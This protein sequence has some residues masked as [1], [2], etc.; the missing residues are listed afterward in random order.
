LDSKIRVEKQV[1]LKLALEN[2]DATLAP[3]PISTDVGG[4][5]GEPDIDTLSNILK[6]FN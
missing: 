5:K 3:V 2:T 4:G 6:T 1:M